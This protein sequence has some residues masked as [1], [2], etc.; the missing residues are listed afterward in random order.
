MLKSTRNIGGKTL[1]G[2]KYKSIM[3]NVPMYLQYLQ[4]RA[5]ALGATEIRASLP[6]SSSLAGALHYATEVVKY[7]GSGDTGI[8][9][10]FINATG[11][12][13]RRLVPDE[14]VFPVRGQTITVKGEAKGITTVD[15][16]PDNPSP[17]SPNITYVLSRPHSGTTVLGGT[18]QVGSWNGDVNTQTTTEILERAKEFAPEL[19]GADGEFE[20]VS[21]QV[22]LRPARKGGARI[23]VEEVRLPGQ[24]SGDG[25]VVCHAYGHAGAGYQNSIGSADKVVRLLSEYFASGTK[26]R[27]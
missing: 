9:D 6:T 11:L 18:K 4:A 7:S 5:V 14:G 16:T 17:E 22:G 19:L 1:T 8:I 15:A 3:I 25:L 26:P 21:E 2:H 13:A 27:L 20:V 24:T 12:E 23:E 10:A